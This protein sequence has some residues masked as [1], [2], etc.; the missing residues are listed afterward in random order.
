MWAAFET[1]G[2]EEEW[3]EEGE[4][5]TEYVASA[6]EE[7][8]QTEEGLLFQPI[9][10]GDNGSSTTI[11]LCHDRSLPSSK[12]EDKECVKAA[13]IFSKAWHWIKKRAKTI[14]KF[15]VAGVMFAGG[16]AVA[17]G[18]VVATA[19]CLAATRGTEEPE[20]IKIALGGGAASIGAFTAGAAIFSS[21]LHENFSR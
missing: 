4:G 5:G 6:E 1:E 16:V 21:A 2:P 19:A 17:A 18:T 7:T 8:S 12:S 10:E 3:E 11:R 9:G 15:G 13:S 20:C 14:V